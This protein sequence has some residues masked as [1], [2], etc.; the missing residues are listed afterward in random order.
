[1]TDKKIYKIIA[2]IIIALV[3]IFIAFVL[4]FRPVSR[5]VADRVLPMQDLYTYRV[6]TDLPG[7]LV[8]VVWRDSGGATTAWS[9]TASILE[10]EDDVL[11]YINKPVIRSNVFASY[12]SV[13]ICF[14]RISD[15]TVKIIYDGGNVSQQKKKYKGIN[16]IYEQGDCPEWPSKE[17]E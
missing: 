15:D 7:D 13:N 6:M 12:R 1:M 5:F 2:I 4:L 9:T 10:S 17:E 3:V 16:F 14:E 11:P 8:L